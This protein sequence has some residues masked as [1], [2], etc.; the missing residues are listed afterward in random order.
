MARKSS[1]ISSLVSA[2][3]K[4][5]LFLA[6]AVGDASDC[7]AAALSDPAAASGAAVAERRARRFQGRGGWDDAPWGFSL[8]SDGV[9]GC[10]GGEADAGAGVPS[11]EQRRRRCVPQLSVGGKVKSWRRVRVA[12]VVA[13]DGDSGAGAGLVALAALGVWWWWWPESSAAMRTMRGVRLRGAARREG[14]GRGVGERVRVRFS[15]GGACPVYGVRASRD[16]FCCDAMLPM[17]FFW[18]D[19][20]V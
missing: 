5:T 4:P 11:L 8:D 12:G 1:A 3:E 19:F 13:G 9:C 6:S 7:C 10:G 20:G 2:T 18:C 14:T 17:V 15:K 16:Y